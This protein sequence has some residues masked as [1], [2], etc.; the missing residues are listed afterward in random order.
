MSKEKNMISPFEEK[1]VSE[2]KYFL[3]T[4]IIWL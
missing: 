2:V 3:W 1:Q 4:F